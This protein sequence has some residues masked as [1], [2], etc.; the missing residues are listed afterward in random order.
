ML[1]RSQVGGEAKQTTRDWP[2]SNGN[3]KQTMPVLQLLAVIPNPETQQITL[4]P[5]RNKASRV[6]SLNCGF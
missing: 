2:Q 1:L 3:A 4:D 5:A 6:P